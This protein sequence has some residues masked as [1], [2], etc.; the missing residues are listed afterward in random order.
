MFKLYGELD[1]S[2][3]LGSV[4][5]SFERRYIE[6]VLKEVGGKRGKASEVLGISRKT[7]WEKMKEY[8]LIP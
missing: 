7:L 4:I 5:K 8:R 1:G 2:K 6:H 3:S